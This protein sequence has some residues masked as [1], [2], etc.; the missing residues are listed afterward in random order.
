MR[1]VKCLMLFCVCLTLA[2]APTFG[3]D[4]PGLSNS[5]TPHGSGPPGSTVMQTKDVDCNLIDFEG[6]VDL[7][8]IGLVPGPVNVTFGTEWWALIDEDDGGS[9]NFANEPSSNTMAVLTGTSDVSIDLDTP[10]QFLE[11]FYT[12]AAVSLPVT[13]TA[14]DSGGGI[15]DQAVGNTIGTSY[16][17]APCSGDPT[18]DFC[19]WDVISFTAATNNISRIEIAGSLGDLFGIDNLNFCIQPQDLVP[20]CLDDLSCTQ[21]TAEGCA[22]A[23]GV[24]VP[25]CDN[26]DCEAVPTDKSTW[27]TLKSNYR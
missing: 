14:Y 8:P 13:V 12:A 5:T 24:E 10:V 19:F 2:S 20:C 4:Q 18:G 27:G 26:V 25:T 1:H 6:L 21:L 16:D 11:F 7:A 23:G 17:G 22:A 3:A 15:V 9:G